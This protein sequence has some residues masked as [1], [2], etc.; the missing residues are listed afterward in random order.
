[1]SSAEAVTALQKCIRRRRVVDLEELFCALGTRSRMTV[2]RRLKMAGYRS[3]FTHAGRF[4]TL[5]DIPVFDE[6][7]LWFHRDAG[8]SLAGNL[9]ESVAWH[10]E[11]SPNGREGDG[12]L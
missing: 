8:F 5:F 9:K 12:P 11:E 10:I 3:S 4:Y 7:G 2:F 1:M 6:L